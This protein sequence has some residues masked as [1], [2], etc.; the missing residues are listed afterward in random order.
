M[1]TPKDI[2]LYI[3]KAKKP[4]K[5]FLLGIDGPGGSGKTTFSNS[6]KKLDNSIQIIHMDDFDLPSNGKIIGD[7]WEKEIGED[8]DWRRLKKEVLTPLKSG[9]KAVFK[10]FDREKEK[11]GKK[12][13]IVAGGIAIVE[14]VFAIRKEIFSLYDLTLWLKTSASLRLKRVLK[15]DGEKMRER[16]EKDW[17]PMEER[18]LKSH[19]PDRYADFILETDLLDN[20]FDL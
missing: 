6:F 1:Q 2:Y 19:H 4:K 11:F 8:T 7:P 17:I 18:Y 14:G 12:E 13:E 10:P 5:T 9:K 16:W 15:R 20:N 3:Q